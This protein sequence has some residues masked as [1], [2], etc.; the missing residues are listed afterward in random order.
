[1]AETRTRA[2]IIDEMMDML[3]EMQRLEAEN[4]GLR[5]RLAA[6][7]TA[8]ADRDRHFLWDERL[9]MEREIG[10]LATR[11]ATAEAERD[12]WQARAE[13]LSTASDMEEPGSL[14]ATPDHPAGWHIL[15]VPGFYATRWEAIDAACSTIP[16]H[17]PNKE[18]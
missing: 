2:E 10:D 3:C 7:E 17:T 11:L 8:L 14:P 9:R 16:S 5:A 13:W 6:A 15:G 12:R 4:D 1:M 18:T